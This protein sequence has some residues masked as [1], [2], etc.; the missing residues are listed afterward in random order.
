MLD[1]VFDTAQANISLWLS[2]AAYCGTSRYEKH[3]FLGPTEG[4]VL[5]KVINDIATDTE[6]NNY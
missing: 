5:T 6:G 3:T 1:W 4:F 2:A